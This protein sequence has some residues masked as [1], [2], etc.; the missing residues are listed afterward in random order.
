MDALDAGKALEGGIGEVK[1]DG[2]GSGSAGSSIAFSGECTPIGLSGR[3]S[4]PLFGLGTILR[5][6]QIML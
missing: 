2:A 3:R 5:E 6:S 4:V 1:G